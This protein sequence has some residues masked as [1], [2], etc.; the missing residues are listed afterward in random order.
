MGVE[1]VQEGEE[2]T[3]GP[4]SAQPVEEG[5][6]DPAAHRGIGG[7]STSVVHGTAA[8]IRMFVEDP[9]PGN[10]ATEERPR[11]QRVI[12]EM[13]EAPIQPGLV[14]AAVGVRR[15]PGGLIA[16][17]GQV[18]GQGRIRGIE[19]ELPLGIEP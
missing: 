9:L 18:L 10:R 4:P 19:R 7:R 16:P 6:V 11:S 15:E 13:G 14:I 2:G 12:L 17:R 1:V 8:E 3:I 5:V